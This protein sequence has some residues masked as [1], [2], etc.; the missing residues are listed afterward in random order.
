MNY[1][2]YVEKLLKFENRLINGY[3]ESLSF[4]EKGGFT[5]CK[6]DFDRMLKESI[7]V[8]EFTT[9][10][11]K[12]K[13]DTVTSCKPLLA[14]FFSINKSRGLL[15]LVRN[16]KFLDN[17]KKTPILFTWDM[18]END[19]CQI[20]TAKDWTIVSCLR[21]MENHAELLNEIVQETI[22]KQK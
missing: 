7:V 14:A 18:I 21:L 8:V 3:A 12:K 16:P 4:Y 17:S 10:D 6:T 2:E 9:K 22:K 15:N 1:K 11:G 13:V 5:H 20:N 19:F